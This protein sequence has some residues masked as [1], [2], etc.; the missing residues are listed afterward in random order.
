VGEGGVRTPLGRGVDAEDGGGVGCG[1]EVWCGVET[2]VE[3]TG[4]VV[5]SG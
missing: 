3:V 1:V 4:C 5:G 2:V